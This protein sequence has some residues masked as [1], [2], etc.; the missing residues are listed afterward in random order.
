MNWYITEIKTLNSPESGT[1]V[2]ASFSVTDG[3]STISSDTKLNPADPSNFIPLENVTEEQV[4]SWVKDSLGDN[5][6]VYEA[7]VVEKTNT[8]IP[9]PTPL[10]WKNEN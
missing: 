8:P 2:I 9:Q 4:V 7:L 6:S 1:I 3:I 5:V 10:P